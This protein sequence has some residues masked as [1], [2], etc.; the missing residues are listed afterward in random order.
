MT[1]ICMRFKVLEAVK[2][3]MLI[4]WVVTPYGNVGRYQRFG[5]TYCLHHQGYLLSLK[6]ETVGFSCKSTRHYSPAYERRQ[7]IK[8]HL[9]ET[10][11]ES[12]TRYQV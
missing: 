6:L 8:I 10:T 9:E 5:E 2:M 7:D 11:V 12:V 1:L 4:F 3:T